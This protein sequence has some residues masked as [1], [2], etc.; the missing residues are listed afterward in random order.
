MFYVVTYSHLFLPTAPTKITPTATWSLWMCPSLPKLILIYEGESSIFV[1][2]STASSP[3]NSDKLFVAK[4]VSQSFD[5]SGFSPNFFTAF[6]GILLSFVML[7]FVKSVYIQMVSIVKAH[8][9]RYI[10]AN[11]EHMG[12][13]WSF[14]VFRDARVPADRQTSTRT[15]QSFDPSL[16]LFECGQLFMQTNDLGWERWGPMSSWVVP[17]KLC[18]I[19]YVTH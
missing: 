7:H 8:F 14:D 6:S 2:R 17:L 19:S 10:W 1:R 5:W 3:G 4:P 12:Y 13:L 15:L 18:C 9:S 11:H 16:A